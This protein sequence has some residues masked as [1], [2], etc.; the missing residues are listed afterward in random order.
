MKYSEK[1]LVMHDYLV[2]HPELDNVLSERWEYPYEN[3]YTNSWSEFQ[4]TIRHLGGYE[5]GGYAGTLTA[6]HNENDEHGDRL[7]Q[8]SVTVSGVCEVRPKVDENGQPV[9]RPKM[10]YVP[11]GEQEQEVEYHCP[12]VWSS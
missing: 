8:L 3:I 1:L 5:K 6:R 9:M 10:N 11:T 7:F 2:K 12:E 4:D